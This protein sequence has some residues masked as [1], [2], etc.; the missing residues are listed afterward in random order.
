[1][2]EC[3]VPDYLRRMIRPEQP[4]CLSCDIENTCIVLEDLDVARTPNDV[5]AI[6]EPS[7]DTDTSDATIPIV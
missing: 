2:I 6:A 1:M 4:V 7:G 3:R 5:A